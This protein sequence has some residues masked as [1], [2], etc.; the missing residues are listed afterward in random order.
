MKTM[1][2]VAAFALAMPVFAGNV[3][4]R[5]GYIIGQE[6]LYQ[7]DLIVWGKAPN[8]QQLYMLTCSQE[9]LIM[10]GGYWLV[11]SNVNNPLKSGRFM[12]TGIVRADGRGYICYPDGQYWYMWYFDHDNYIE[13]PIKNKINY[14]G[15]WG[16]TTDELNRHFQ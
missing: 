16:P 4:D 7:R 1:M 12:W 8:G 2:A 13:G 11:S 10:Q 9:M 5:E 15:S 6:P 14:D 3:L